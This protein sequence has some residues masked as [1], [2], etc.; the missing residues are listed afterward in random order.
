MIT[1]LHLFMMLR[2]FCY[3]M[4]LTGVITALV[5]YA[6][7]NAGVITRRVSLRGCL[8]IGLLWPLFIL[9]LV[10]LVWRFRKHV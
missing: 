7:F 1:H 9:L 6:L 4:V 3:G 10:N 2:A 8:M 5:D